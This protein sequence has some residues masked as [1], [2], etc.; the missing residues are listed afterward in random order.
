ME[1]KKAQTIEQLERE[2]AR[3]IPEGMGPP[4]VKGGPL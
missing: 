2:N 1:H 3:P 4:G